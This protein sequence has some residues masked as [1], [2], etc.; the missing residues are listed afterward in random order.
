MIMSESEFISNE[1]KE[2]VAK[3][4]I[5][6][7]VKA[8]DDLY[9]IEAVASEVQQLEKKQTILAQYKKKKVDDID[10]QAR[11]IKCKIAFYKDIIATT[12]KANNE[13]GIKFP[14]F[15]SISTRNNPGKWVIED[16]DEFITW[17]EE[18]EKSGE[19]VTGVVDKVEQKNVVKR[20]ADKLLSAWQQSGKLEDLLKRSP[21]GISSPAVKKE[22]SKL[23]A[24]ITFEEEEKEEE[25]DAL[26]PE[27]ST[28]SV[29]KKNDDSIPSAP[30]NE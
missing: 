12:L 28:S 5:D 16:E 22:P 24:T 19:K 20:E 6:G 21:S 1:A 18:A 17:V 30:V 15:C 13:K 7:Q 4:F 3:I 9:D 29:P 27:A 23:S 14:G 2:K 25:I 11:S 10:E 8:L 26:A